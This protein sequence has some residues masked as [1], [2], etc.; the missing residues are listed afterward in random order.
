MDNE[1]IQIAAGQTKNSIYSWYIWPENRCIP[2]KISKITGMEIHGNKMFRN[3][4]QMQYVKIKQALK[5]LFNKFSNVPYYC[6]NANFDACMLVLACEQAGVDIESKNISFCDTLFVFKEAYPKQ[7]SYKQE[8]LVQGII[9]KNY[10]AHN[11]VGDVCSS[12]E[13]C[14]RVDSSVI[15]NSKHHFTVSKVTSKIQEAR[16]KKKFI[17]G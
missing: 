15:E 1:I 8:N 13:L 5:E 3:S 7:V 10:D 14:E 9:G 6:H 16:N 11:A 2:S 4:I 17:D 12:M